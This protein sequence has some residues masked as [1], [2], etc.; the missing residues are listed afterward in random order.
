MTTKAA[1]V[2][3]FNGARWDE[4]PQN[5]AGEYNGVFYNGATTYFNGATN[6]A[7][8]NGASDGLACS[9]AFCNADSNGMSCNGAS[10]DVSHNATSNEVTDDDSAP[11][12]YRLNRVYGVLLPTYITK[13]LIDELRVMPLRPDDLFIVT[14]PKS[15]TTWMQQIVKLIRSNGVDDSRPVTDVIPWV[16]QYPEKVQVR[17]Y[18]IFF[19]V[20]RSRKLYG[21]I[22]FSP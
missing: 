2:N 5:G 18:Y 17:Q 1:A 20:R 12:P 22:F 3:G 16:E 7:F 8:C 21:E 6:G 4:H 19:F 14:Y 9:K 15:G 13:K 10:T 11:A